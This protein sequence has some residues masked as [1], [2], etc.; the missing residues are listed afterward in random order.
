MDLND[1]ERLLELIKT[2]ALE[3]REVTLSSGRTS[4]YYVDCKRVTL[5]SEGAYLSAKLM[6]EKIHP[7]VVAVGGLTLGADPLVASIAV[8][9]HLQ[10][11]GL[12]G[13]IVRKEPKKH[14]TMNYVEGP[15]LEMGAKVAVL[16]DVVTSGASLLRAVERINAAGYQAAQA[17]ALLDRQ[18]GGKEAIKARGLALHALFC[19]DDLGLLGSGDGADSAQE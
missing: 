1:R 2:R 15:G 11:R 6:L 10:H 8:L 5:N 18:E 17:L 9:S 14:G 7:D 19:R 12:S 16:E 3:V 13:L 4:N